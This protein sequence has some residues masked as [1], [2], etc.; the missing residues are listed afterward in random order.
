MERLDARRTA[1]VDL[2]YD[3]GR[4]SAVEDDARREVIGAEI[5]KGADRPCLADDLGD[6]E[7]VE[8]VLHRDDE[9]VLGEMRLDRP[10]GLGGVLGFHAEQHDRHSGR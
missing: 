8:A 7:L 3:H 2:A 4:A 10:S 6:H 5:D 9:A 1:S